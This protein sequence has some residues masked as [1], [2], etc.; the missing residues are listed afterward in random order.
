MII[1]INNNNMDHIS[2]FFFNAFL[3]NFSGKNIF[4]GILNVE[5]ILISKLKIKLLIFPLPTFKSN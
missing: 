4:I 2:F 1:F 3:D 5:E